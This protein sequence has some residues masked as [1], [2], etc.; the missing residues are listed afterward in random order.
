MA[1]RVKATGLVKTA[2]LHRKTVGIDTDRDFLVVG[3][4][5]SHDVSDGWFITMKFQ[6][7]YDWDRV[8]PDPTDRVD[9]TVLG[10]AVGSDG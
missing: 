7:R 4:L 10:V 9:L 3:F 1:R 2:L 6:E 8:H 5:D